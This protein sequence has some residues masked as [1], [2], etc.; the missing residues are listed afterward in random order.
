MTTLEYPTFYCRYCGFSPDPDNPWQSQS[1]DK[2]GCDHCAN[3][4]ADRT[5][6]HA[7]PDAVRRRIATDER[8]TP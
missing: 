1:S 2:T 4:C 8:T 6:D 3:G 5:H 7:M